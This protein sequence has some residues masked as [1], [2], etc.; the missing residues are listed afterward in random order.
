[1]SMVVIV[2]LKM[3]FF[4]SFLSQET[5]GNANEALLFHGTGADAAKGI[6]VRLPAYP[7]HFLFQWN[8]CS[9]YIFIMD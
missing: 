2:L 9:A 3:N 6:L 1:M 7:A 8:P 4:I 5:K